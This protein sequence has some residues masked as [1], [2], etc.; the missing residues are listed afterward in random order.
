MESNA[1]DC[2]AP[3][4]ALGEIGTITPLPYPSAA[5]SPILISPN[6]TGR[7]FTHPAS[8]R[9]ARIVAS[10]S[11]A[12]ESPTTENENCWPTVEGRSSATI[13]CCCS[14]DRVRGNFSFA[15]AKFASAACCSASAVACC[16][17]ASCVSTFCCAAL[18]S[19]A[20]FQDQQLSHLRL[21]PA[22]AVCPSRSWLPLGPN[23][24][25]SIV[26]LGAC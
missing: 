19:D 1:A 5:S 6:P 10:K 9:I 22:L 8:F 13:L 2:L 21:P 17:M 20:A 11:S 12:S 16:W 14:G 3:S 26:Q 18:A 4:W 25:A 24:S 23:Q 15:N 7:P